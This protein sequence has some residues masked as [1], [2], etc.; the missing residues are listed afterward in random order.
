MKWKNF[1]DVASLSE[2]VPSI[3]FEEYLQREGQ[4]IHK[5]GL[6]WTTVLVNNIW[7]AMN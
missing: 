6:L 4:V 7:L 1:F 3:E 2:Y 5:V